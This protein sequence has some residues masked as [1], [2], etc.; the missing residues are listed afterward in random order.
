M[1]EK[2]VVRSLLELGWGALLAMF[3]GM[4]KILSMLLNPDVPEMRWLAAFIRLALAL[5][6]GVAMAATIPETWEY[7]DFIVVVCG[8]SGGGILDLAEDLLKSRL[9]GW[10]K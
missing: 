10:T 6:I 3:G 5:V 2:D 8:Y 1:D 7:R 9:R 4:A